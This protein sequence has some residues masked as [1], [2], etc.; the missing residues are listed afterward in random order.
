M[1]SYYEQRN[2]ITRETGGIRVTIQN[3]KLDYFSILT[4]MKLIIAA[5]RSP[6]F[7][8]NSERRVWSCLDG[9]KHHALDAYRIPDVIKRASSQIT[10]ATF[11]DLWGYKK[12]AFQASTRSPKILADAG[13]PVALH[14][15]QL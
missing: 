7:L 5:K 10:T 14:Y 11:S 2:K 13:I 12:E 8:N 6:T 4:P 1:T 9:M 3:F 15:H